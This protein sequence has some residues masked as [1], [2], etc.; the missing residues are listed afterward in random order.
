M[1]HDAR[2]IQ[3]PHPLHFGQLELRT[4]ES[5]NTQVAEINQTIFLRD[6]GRHRRS[7]IRKLQRAK[8][9]D[10]MSI[11]FTSGATGNPK[12]AML[13]NDNIASNIEAVRHFTHLRPADSVLG[14]L[15]FFHSFRY[16][17]SMWLPLCTEPSGV[18]HFNPLDASTV[19]KL[20]KT[21]RSTILLATPPLLRSYMKQ[22]SEKQMRSTNMVIVGAEQMPDDLPDSFRK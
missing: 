21:H 8:H 9:D 13:T 15:P 20:I 17:V 10:V 3:T 1:T 18:F 16:T 12:G 5:S 14:V 11:I 2:I 7:N 6:I 22:C 4:D 19:G